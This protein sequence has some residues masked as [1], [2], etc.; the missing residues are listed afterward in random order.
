[1]IPEP[2]KNVESLDAPLGH[3][4]GLSDLA[5]AAAN[6]LIFLALA[7][8]AWKSASDIVGAPEVRIPCPWRRLRRPFSPT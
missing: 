4:E 2:H 3:L 5:K 8:E 7:T 1:M 6:F